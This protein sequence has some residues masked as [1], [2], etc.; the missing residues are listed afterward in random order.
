M[1]S[2]VSFLTLKTPIDPTT[3]VCWVGVI[4]INTG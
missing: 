4:S 2:D 3:K 1:D